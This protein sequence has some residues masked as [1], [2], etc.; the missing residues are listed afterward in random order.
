MA[1]TM[2]QFVVHSLVFQHCFDVFKIVWRRECFC[3]DKFT[4]DRSRVG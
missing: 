2:S 1:H 3:L 4:K